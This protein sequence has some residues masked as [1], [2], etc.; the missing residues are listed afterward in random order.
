MNMNAMNFLLGK[1]VAR[2]VGEERST[3]L[4]LL[5]GL[6]PGYQGVLLSAVIARREAPTTPAAPVDP[7]VVAQQQEAI[8]RLLDSLTP[9][10]AVAK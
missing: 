9:P 7:K 5:A 10:A 4:G 1:A 8:K 2:D 6:M 3:Q